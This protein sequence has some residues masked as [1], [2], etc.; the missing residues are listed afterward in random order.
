MKLDGWNYIPRG[1]GMQWDL[2]DAP[3]WLRAWFRFPFLDRFAYP[4]VVHRGFA[5]LSPHHASDEGDRE[6]VPPG[7]RIAPARVAITELR[8]EAPAPGRGRTSRDDDRS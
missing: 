2:S 5:W 3:L 8:A 6:Q 7:W 4:V 1:Y